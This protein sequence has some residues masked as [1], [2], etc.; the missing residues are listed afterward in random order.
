MLS[1]KNIINRHFRF[2]LV[3]QHEQSDCGPAAL[4]SVLKYYGGNDHLIHIRELCRTGPHGTTI[5]DM[6]QAA[7]RLGIKATGATGRYEE[8]L[9]ETLPANCPYCYKSAAGTFYC[10]L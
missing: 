2:P 3:R 4:L 8:L 5:Y 9:K 10:N 6:I 1:P 7:D